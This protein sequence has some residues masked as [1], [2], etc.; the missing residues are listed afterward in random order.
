MGGDREAMIEAAGAG[1]LIIVTYDLM[2]RESSYFAAKEFATVILDEA[3]AIKNRNTKR[4][5]AAMRLQADL[6]IILTGT[7]VEN[8]L[9]E[10]WNLFPDRPA[11]GKWRAANSEGIRLFR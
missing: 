3:Q 1:D 8:H 5:E 7:P 4:S 10:L 11:N 6:K 9:G 2:A